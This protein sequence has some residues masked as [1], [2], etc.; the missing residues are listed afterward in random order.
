MKVIC[1]YCN[2]EAQLVTGEVIYPKSISF[3]DL[4][5]WQC[6][7]CG[8]CVGTHEGKRHKPLGTL[9]NK[10]LRMLRR[11]AHNAFDWWWRKQGIRRSEA[12]TELARSLG[13]PKS[14]CHIAMFDEAV[15]HKVVDLYYWR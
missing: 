11:E 3:H 8:A 12:Y 6:A 9:A 10:H 5:F 15:C 1:P 2:R 14:E 4:Y 13:I 7:P